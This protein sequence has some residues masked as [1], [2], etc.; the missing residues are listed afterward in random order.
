M[1]QLNK[2]KKTQTKSQ[3]VFFLF[4]NFVLRTYAITNYFPFFFSP[5][6]IHLNLL[7]SW[8]VRI[9]FVGIFLMM[10]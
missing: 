8:S 6:E 2:M 9:N 1:N 5:G 10:S 3:Q 4:I 7:N